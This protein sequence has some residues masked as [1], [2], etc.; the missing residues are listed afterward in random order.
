MLRHLSAALLLVFASPAWSETAWLNQQSGQVVLK[1]FAFDVLKNFN[2]TWWQGA[3]F[4]GA[5]FC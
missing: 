5:S 1:D 2:L 4:N 3:M